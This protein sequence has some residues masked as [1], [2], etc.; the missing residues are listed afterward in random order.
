MGR[1]GGYAWQASIN[2]IILPRIRVLMVGI[3]EGWLIGF[4]RDK[5]LPER[6]SARFFT[7][8]YTGAVSLYMISYIRI[9]CS[10][11]RRYDKGDILKN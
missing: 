1:L 6:S 7:A 9:I 4:I 11:F 5:T 8:A 10:L 2:R 3:L